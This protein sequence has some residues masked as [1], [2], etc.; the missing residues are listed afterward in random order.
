MVHAQLPTGFAVFVYG[1]AGI[2]IE[3]SIH[4]YPTP[5]IT[6]NL[7][8]ANFFFGAPAAFTNIVGI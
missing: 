1:P 3:Q 4:D 2:E 6:I 8:L 5:L 7:P